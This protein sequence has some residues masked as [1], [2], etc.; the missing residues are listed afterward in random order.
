MAVASAERLGA[1]IKCET[2]STGAWWFLIRGENPK[3]LLKERECSENQHLIV[4]LFV[5]FEYTLTFETKIEKHTQK[6]KFTLA[7]R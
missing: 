5:T 2:K 7:I 4:S 1:L 3:V 6:K